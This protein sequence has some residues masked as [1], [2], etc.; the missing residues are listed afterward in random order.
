MIYL[1]TIFF[2]AKTGMT[3]IIISTDMNVVFSEK[4]DQ[5]FVTATHVKTMNIRWDGVQLVW[6]D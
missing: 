2:L 5:L 1:W 3:D 6:N 4:K